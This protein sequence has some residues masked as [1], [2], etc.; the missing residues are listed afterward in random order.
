MND[1]SSV[2]PS[3]RE[4]KNADY[5]VQNPANV[6][7]DNVKRSQTV[8]YFGA[9]KESV[10][11]TDG[12]TTTKTVLT[13]SEA[14][15]N[16]KARFKTTE[17]ASKAVTELIQKT[18]EFSYKGVW[19]DELIKFNQTSTSIYKTWYNNYLVKK[20]PQEIEELPAKIQVSV[21]E[22]IDD[23]LER[24]SVSLANKTAEELANEEEKLMRKL[25]AIQ[26]AKAGK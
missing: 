5:S 25:A 24:S 15:K 20:T 13:A 8:I 4:V 17:E 26:A 6:V 1:Y 7:L 12:K 23:R 11:G 14:E 9:V 10:K 3:K 16:F 22:I 18:V 19:I 2:A 21:R